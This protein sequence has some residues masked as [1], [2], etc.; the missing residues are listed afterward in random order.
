M[1][2]PGRM[3]FSSLADSM[4]EVRKFSSESERTGVAG[5]VEVEVEV[6]VSGWG[7]GGAAVEKR[8]GTMRLAY[9]N[10]VWV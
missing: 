3:M 5:A 8:L 10:I 9:S 2:L 6:V 1:E 7:E 4:V